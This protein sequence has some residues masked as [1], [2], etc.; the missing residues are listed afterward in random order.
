[1]KAECPQGPDF[2]GAVGKRRVHRDHGSDDGSQFPPYFELN[3]VLTEAK[4]RSIRRSRIPRS[5]R[6]PSL[7]PD[8]E[9][10][11]NHQ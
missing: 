9:H 4:I 7:M 11:G 2:T 10:G 6:A 1:M 5:S 3:P 8:S